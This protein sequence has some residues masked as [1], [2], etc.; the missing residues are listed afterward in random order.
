MDFPE[1]TLQWP[2]E[3]LKWANSMRE[4]IKFMAYAS[5]LP[6][7]HA[8]MLEE[9]L[10]E[11][12]Q[13]ENI[14]LSLMGALGLRDKKNLLPNAPDS[15]L[16]DKVKVAEIMYSTLGHA[17][18]FEHPLSTGNFEP[19][20]HEVKTVNCSA[21]R[22]INYVVAK[23]CDLNPVIREV[24]DLVGD[25][26]PEAFGHSF[27]EFDVGTGTNW[28]ICSQMRWLGPIVWDTENKR[29]KITK[30]DHKTGE[31]KIVEYSYTQRDT[32][33]EQE[34]LQRIFYFRSSEGAASMLINGQRLQCPE[35][36]GWKAEKPMKTGWYIKYSPE[37]RVLSISTKHMRPLVSNR[38]LE[39]RII[40]NDNG[41]PKSEDVVGYFYAADAW[42][43]FLG[44]TPLFSLPADKIPGVIQGLKE[45]KPQEHPELEK[46]LQRIFLNKPN[47]PEEENLEK[48]IRGS[49]AAVMSQVSRNDT[50][51]FILMEALYLDEVEGAADG[52]LYTRQRRYEAFKLLAEDDDMFAQELAKMEKARERQEREIIRAERNQR[53]VKK[54]L[55]RVQAAPNRLLERM[56]ILEVQRLANEDERRYNEFRTQ[57]DLLIYQLEN[58][59]RF[60]DEAADRYIFATTTGRKYTQSLETL[61][62]EAKTRFGDEFDKRIMAA[63]ARISGE[64]LGMIAFAWDNL[65]AAQYKD[66]LLDKVRTYRP[67]Q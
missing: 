16:E 34:L 45:L 17:Y 48:A 46:R 6:V 35:I 54:Y 39:Y 36:D 5:T 57:A 14:F 30:R 22:N 32:Y 24:D 66:V 47:N 52:F 13:G 9:R 51:K 56:E 18:G 58:F 63:Y 29:V 61:E 19:W 1:V 15:A 59:A 23:A 60:C 25:D 20:P 40:F 49:Y 67:I 64:F 11:A 33:T 4:S 50:Y 38:G 8:Q 10:R 2:E 43:E 12:T 53:K 44:A 3:T 7:N 37:E 28:A 26:S 65:K 31:E 62:A 42:A 27:I 55:R 21:Q 41:L